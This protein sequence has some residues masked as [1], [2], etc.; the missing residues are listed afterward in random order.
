M[1]KVMTFN[2]RYG[3]AIDGGNHS[4]RRKKLIIERIRAFDP[5][6]AQPSE[7]PRII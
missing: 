3:G 5:Q 6:P 4:T 2:I 7:M 1:F